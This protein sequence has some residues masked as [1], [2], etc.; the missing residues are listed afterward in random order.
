MRSILAR[1]ALAACLVVGVGSCGDGVHPS[2]IRVLGV[3]PGVCGS[4]GVLF[5]QVPLRL[6]PEGQGA[7]R[8]VRVV[9][10]SG[11]TLAPLTDSEAPFVVDLDTRQLTDGSVKLALSAEDSEGE[12]LSREIDVCVDNNGPQLTILSPP[13]GASIGIED[14]KVAVR[15]SVDDSA[16]VA[17][18]TARLATAG[19]Y[20]QVDCQPPDGKEQVCTLRPGD[21][22]L[23][24]EPST[25]SLITLTVTARDKVGHETSVTRQLEVGTRLRWRFNAGAP[26]TWAAAIS[27]TGNVI[28][29]TDTGVMHVLDPAGKPVCSAQTPA[30]AGQPDPITTPPT[31]GVVAGADH[32]FVG[33]TQTLWS[34]DPTTCQPRWSRG[35]GL[36]FASQPVH[37]AAVDV[38]YIGSYGEVATQGALLAFR[39]SSGQ[40]VGSFPIAPVN[41]AVTASPVLAADGKTVYIGSSDLKLYAINVENPAA[42]AQ[43]WTFSPGGKIETRALVTAN[44]IYVASLAKTLHARDPAGGPLPGF[45]FTA[46]AGFLSSPVV[47]ADGV[48]YIGSLDEKLY[49][50][51]TSGKALATF[52]TGRML[53]TAPA[54]GPGGVVYA[55]RTKPGRLYALTNKLELLWSA[56]PGSSETHEFKATPVVAG[57]T[58]YIGS[59]S[60]FFYAFDATPPSSN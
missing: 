49:A 44:A 29:T 11:G 42:M 31:V 59:S 24:Y 2:G 26:I 51:D 28:V 41:D 39:G 55:A 30:V 38:V 35:G 34:L 36:Y 56:Q 50:L 4:G 20:Q 16:G 21:L 27:S 12:T 14:A 60:G 8:S 54:I 45:A 37:D 10:V 47:G 19:A 15:V 1:L 22:A 13:P 23:A 58:V 52:Q 33:S 3:T 32:V 6:E 43:R 5:G 48:L 40:P 53:R 57:N 25:K 9:V 17:G 18:V 46:E 7:F